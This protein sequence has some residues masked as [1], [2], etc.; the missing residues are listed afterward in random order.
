MPRAGEVIGENKTELSGQN[1]ARQVDGGCF[2]YP[3]GQAGPAAEMS[4]RG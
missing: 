4:Q 3:G 2:R 1:V